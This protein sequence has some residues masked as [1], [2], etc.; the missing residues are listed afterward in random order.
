[1]QKMTKNSTSI[2]FLGMKNCA[3]Y[4][5]IVLFCG[6][7]ILSCVRTQKP[8]EFDVL[9]LG[10]GT[11]GT[12]AGIQ[13]ARLGAQTAIVEPSPWLG[14]MLTAA[15]VSATDGNHHMPAGIWGEFRDSLYARYGGPEAVFTGWVS[16]TQFEPHVGAEIFARMAERERSLT[17]FLNSYYRDIQKKDTHWEVEV[18]TEEGVR[19]LRAKILIDGTD[20][21][22]VAALVGAG[23]DLGMDAAAETGEAMAPA[24]GNDLIQDLTYVAILKDYGPDT[25]ATIPEPAGYDREQFLCSCQK[26]CP[27]PAENVLPCETML[28]YAKLPNDKYLINWPRFGNDFYAP[29]V[30][31]NQPERYEV[32]RDAKNKT[33]QFVYFIQTELGYP[34][35]G[36]ADDEF[37]TDDLLPFL[38]YYREGRRIHGLVQVDVNHLL[39]PYQ[40][41]TPLYKT[42]IAVGDYPIDHHHLEVPDAPE[43]DFPSVPSFNIPLGALI[44]KDVEGLLI[45][46]KAISV[47]NIVNGSSRLQPVI[48]QVGQAAG[49]LAALAVREDVPPRQVDVRTV[50]STLLAASGYLVPSY[51]VS[52]EHPRFA[53]IQRVA[54]AGILPGYGKPYAWANRTWYYPDSTMSLAELQVGLER[55]G[56]S[57]TPMEIATETLVTRNILSRLLPDLNIITPDNNEAGAMTRT[58]LA[59]ILDEKLKPFSR[60]VDHQGQFLGPEK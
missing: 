14:G 27:T 50:Q 58:E 25:N 40:Y 59:E 12:A 37:P 17:L 31:M 36:L 45:A 16:N 44:S 30:E 39:N 38:P 41:S 26:L 47:T 29:I 7:F 2:C 24:T 8:L 10:G 32:W 33:L 43:I 35:L 21:G 48:L 5:A 20:M 1:M 34:N 49:A 28:S 54:A 56:I 60:A 55:A 9:I 42:G 4:T 52:P 51:D 18:A 46:D 22:D 23:Y 13:S 57:Y 19:T 11:G 3:F 6:F 15:G 53:A